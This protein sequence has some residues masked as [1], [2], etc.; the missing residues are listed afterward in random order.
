MSQWN[1][2]FFLTSRYWQVSR[3]VLGVL[4]S[5][6]NG[7]CRR[8]SINQYR[9]QLSELDIAIS[10][11]VAPNSAAEVAALLITRV[12]KECGFGRGVHVIESIQDISSEFIPEYHCLSDRESCTMHFLSITNS[13]KLPYR[14]LSSDLAFLCDSHHLDHEHSVCRFHPCDGRNYTV[15]DLLNGRMKAAVCELV[16]L[17]FNLCSMKIKCT[18]VYPSSFFLMLSNICLVLSLSRDSSNTV[19][20]HAKPSEEFRVSFTT[21]VRESEVA[22]VAQFISS[23]LK[24]DDPVDKTYLDHS[25]SNIRLCIY[26]KSDNGHLEHHDKILFGRSIFHNQRSNGVTVTHNRDMREAYSISELFYDDASDT[27]I[28]EQSLNSNAVDCI[29]LT[30]RNCPSL[31]ADKDITVGLSAEY[32]LKHWNDC[33]LIQN[34]VNQ[35]PLYSSALMN[36]LFVTQHDKND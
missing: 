7:R 25:I 34:S 14:H 15:A 5:I 32:F 31:R 21:A 11:T 16:S 30:N 13:F 1:I 28:N 27:N 24:L 33:A 17:W 4:K 2:S 26:F 8:I 20:L 3:N 36:C 29:N 6:S 12:V 10:G 22:R 35:A 19:D 9:L 23:I 18:V